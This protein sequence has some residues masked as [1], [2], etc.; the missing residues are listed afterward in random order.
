MVEITSAGYMIF[1]IGIMIVSG[2]FGGMV[3]AVLAERE[4][5][6]FI[7]LIIKHTFIGIVAAMTVPLILHLFSSDLLDT[8]Q[9]KPLKLFIL[10]GICILYSL[11]SARFL[12]RFAGNRL[13]DDKRYD[14]VPIKT[15][16]DV[17]KKEK[18]SDTT[19]PPISA[20]KV[21][22]LENQLKILQCLARVKDAKMTLAGLMN[23]SGMTQKEFDEI[24]SLLMAKGAIAQELS[25]GRT[26]H[27]VL[28][29]RGR[30]QLTK[31]AG[32]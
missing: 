31:M 10:S 18:T 21:K 28:T 5:Q 14:Q 22:S 30:Q 15:G 29:S 8:G 2:A 17:A 4:D 3:S 7:S 13:K 25:D 19:V 24:L 12:D 23:D 26:L 6:P 1:L 20:E 11:F 27:F 32:S 9:T 16:N